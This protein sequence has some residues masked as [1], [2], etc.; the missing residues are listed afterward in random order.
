LPT[1]CLTRTSEAID[2]GRNA[3]TSKVGDPVSF[4]RIGERWVLLR[5]NGESSVNGRFAGLDGGPP[6]CNFSPPYLCRIWRLAEPELSQSLT[7]P[8]NDTGPCV[9]RHTARLV[10]GEREK[11]NLRVELFAQYVD[12]AFHHE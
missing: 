5:E 8:E 2:L 10:W 9:F 6:T 3:L 11:G 12:Y 4:Y 1:R 7:Q